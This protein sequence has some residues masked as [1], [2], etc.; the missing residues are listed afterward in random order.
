MSI[1]AVQHSDPVMHIYIYIHTYTFFISLLNVELVILQFLTTIGIHSVTSKLPR[2]HLGTQGQADG[3]AG[4]PE[5]TAFYIC[6]YFSDPLLLGEGIA[7]WCRAAPYRLYAYV[8]LPLSS[9]E[10]WGRKRKSD[11]LKDLLQMTCAGSTLFPRELQK[12]DE[13]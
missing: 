8:S 4:S 9:R 6:L 2:E 13:G 1:S 7:F 11:G 12:Q 5:E 3:D 10:D